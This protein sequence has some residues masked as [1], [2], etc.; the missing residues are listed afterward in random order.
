MTKT[1]RLRCQEEFGGVP[2]GRPATHLVGLPGYEGTQYPACTRHAQAWAPNCR[3]RLPGNKRR[4]RGRA[5]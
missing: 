5:A 3:R 2:C 1:D 4:P